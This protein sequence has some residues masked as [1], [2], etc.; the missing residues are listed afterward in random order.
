M[1]NDAVRLKNYAVDF[2][3]N[4]SGGAFIC[5]TAGDHELLYVN[6]RLVEIFECEST[7]EFMDFVGGTLK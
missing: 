7:E 1:I 2:A 6:K 3:D 5:K 4:M